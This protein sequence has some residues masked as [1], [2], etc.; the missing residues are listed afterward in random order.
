MPS[1]LILNFNQFQQNLAK[2]FIKLHEKYTGHKSL[3]PPEKISTKLPKIHT[4]PYRNSKFHTIH[5]LEKWKVEFHTFPG[6]P[7]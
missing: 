5:D 2:L 4:F 1:I 7:Y 3:A 6:I